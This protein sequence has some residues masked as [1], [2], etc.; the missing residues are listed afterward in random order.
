MSRCRRFSHA[1]HGHQTPSVLLPHSR[2]TPG[3]WRWRLTRSASGPLW[4]AWT[5]PCCSAT[6]RRYGLD[7][8]TFCTRQWP[9]VL[10]CGKLTD[11]TLL[12]TSQIFFHLRRTVRSSCTSTLGPS[13]AWPSTGRASA[14]CRGPRTRRC[15][16]RRCPQVCWSEYIAALAF[17]S[18]LVWRD[19]YLLCLLLAPID[20]LAVIRSCFS[21][22]DVLRLWS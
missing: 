1:I 5:G 22:G 14:Q 8:V 2:P 7:S 4:A 19:H 6:S 3:L 11:Q 10:P 21:G 9:Y 13:R 16:S 18:C 20:C 15:V 12:I 17:L